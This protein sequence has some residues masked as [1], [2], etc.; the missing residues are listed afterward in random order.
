MLND[1]QP[2]DEPGKA[3]S[4]RTTLDAPDLAKVVA[5]MDV[6]LPKP[7]P[8]KTI[9]DPIAAIVSILFGILAASGLLSQIHMTT[10]MLM[11]LGGAFVAV[12]AFGRAVWHWRRGEAVALQDKIAAL[13]GSAV[14][15]AT[16]AGLPVNQLSPDLVG[17]IAAMVA[18]VFTTRR[19]VKAAV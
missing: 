6:P 3:P 1:V 12:M 5:S 10:A 8:S 16:A 11:A 17:A 13:L 14:T 15:I 7:P 4:A 2:T 18:T 9:A 19:A